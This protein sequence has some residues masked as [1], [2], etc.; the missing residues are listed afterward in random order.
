MKKGGSTGVLSGDSGELE[1]HDLISGLQDTKL[2]EDEE[3]HHRLCEYFCAKALRGEIGVDN[4][5]CQTDDFPI[6]I[7]ENQQDLSPSQTSV[8]IIE[9]NNNNQIFKFEELL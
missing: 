2:K 9:I 4:K 7:S 3:A 8:K 6:D 5:N 1:F